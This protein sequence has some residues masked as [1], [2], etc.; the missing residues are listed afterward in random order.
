MDLLGPSI[1]K[2]KTTHEF[3]LRQVLMLSYQMLSRIEFLHKKGFIHCDIKPSNFLFG[4]KETQTQNIIYLI[5]FGLACSYIDPSTGKHISYGESSNL[6]GTPR[7]SS[8]NVQ[9]GIK[10]SRRDDLISLGY[11]II[12]LLK[13]SLPWQSQLSGPSANGIEMIKAIIKKKIETKIS[14]LCSSLPSQI[15]LFF[16]H[17]MG[18]QF[19]DEPDYTYLRELIKECM[20]DNDF[21]FDNDF[22]I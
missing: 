20:R 7:F 15:E 19:A 11:S 13:G 18:L 10:P 21:L 9:T 14:D 16:T 4:T 2:V 5:D 6:S 3:S 22:H 8:L 1:E 17:I 12:Y